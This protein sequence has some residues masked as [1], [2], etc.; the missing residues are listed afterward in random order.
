MAARAGVAVSDSVTGPYEYLGSTR[1]NGRDSRDMTLLQDD[2]GKA[3]LVHSS[4]WNSVMLISDLSDNYLSFT[5]HFTRHFDHGKKNTG[6]ESPA[7]FKHGGKYFIIS[8]GT[9]GWNPNAAEYAVSD[10]IHGPWRVIGNPCIGPDAGL[11]F[12]SQDTFVL[13]VADRRDMFIFMA[14]RWNPQNLRDSRY[15]WLPLQI[16][17]EK[18]TVEWMDVWSPGSKEFQSTPDNQCH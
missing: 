15:V 9:T 6:R 18:L 1:P 8:S 12:R 16:D 17:G 7:L 11:T 4:D 14:D 13:A 5:G 2:D 10:S 3:Y